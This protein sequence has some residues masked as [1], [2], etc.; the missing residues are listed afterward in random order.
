MRNFP[1]RPAIT[2]PPWRDPARS[3]SSSFSRALPALLLLLLLLH[4][5]SSRAT[6]G[7]GGQEAPSGPP[8]A[9]ALSLTFIDVGQ[10]DAALLTSPTG[11]RVLIDGGPPEGSA[12]LLASLRRQGAESLDLIILTHPH[13]DHLG[14]LAKVVRALPVRNFLDSGFS[15][16]SPGYAALLR[17]LEERGVPVRQASAGRKIDLG[18]GAVLTLLGPPQPYLDHTRSDVNANSVVGRLSWRQVSALLTGDAEPETEAWLLRQGVPLEAG[19][20]KV[21]HHGGRF[22]STAAF[23]RAV[24]PQVAV[25]S[26]AARN[27]YGHPTAEALARLGAAGARVYRTDQLGD[28]T[29]RSLDGASWTVL[30][31]GPADPGG[32]A[33]PAPSARPAPAAPPA[34]DEPA[35]PRRPGPAKAETPRTEAPTPSA[36][37]VVGSSRSDVFHRPDCAAAGK[38]RPENLLRFPSREDALARGRRPA[39]DCHP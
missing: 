12:A 13:L 17:A 15:H 26:V 14:G 32:P 6:P 21:A 10:G 38:I 39:A 16:P 33:A 22:S 4:G 36:G 27:D 18:D 23:L 1:R 3:R 30:S 11:K 28:V 19:L 5:C 8:P 2:D 20:L 9:G 25:I 7:R 35:E 29:V 24:R 37:A 34:P 31:G